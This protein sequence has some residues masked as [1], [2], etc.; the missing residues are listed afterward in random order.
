M[1]EYR[2]NVFDNDLGCGEIIGR[3]RYNTDLDYWDG[4]N[5]TSG[6]TGMHK[7]I[8]KLK[9]GSFVI[10]V[11]SQWQGSKDFAY[12]VSPQEALEEIL[13]S[14]NSQLLELTKFKKLKELQILLDNEYEDLEEEK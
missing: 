8:T 5:W 7:G 11:G 12:T 13:K 14:G 10:I 4:R 2:V 6:S 9:D 3:V 1:S